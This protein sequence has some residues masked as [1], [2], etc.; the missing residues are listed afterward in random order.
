MENE[1]LP[2]DGLFDAAARLIERAL[3]Q[4]DRREHQRCVECG[5]RNFSNR[6]H[7]RI[8]EWTENM[9]ARLRRAARVYKTGWDEIEPKSGQD[10]AVDQ[11]R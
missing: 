9:P 10:A 3:E 4:L 11:R 1:T 8:Q 2:P 5:S 6:A 7:A